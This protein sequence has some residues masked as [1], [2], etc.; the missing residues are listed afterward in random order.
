MLLQSK[1]HTNIKKKKSSDEPESCS[2]ALL[3]GYLVLS[4]K[5]KLEK[6]VEMIVEKRPI[7][8][9]N[10]GFTLQLQF[11]SSDFFKTVNSTIDV[12]F[13]YWMKH[14]KQQAAQS[15]GKIELK[16]QEEEENHNATKEKL[17]HTQIEIEFCRTKIADLVFHT[18]QYIAAS[19]EE[20][21]TLKK[22]LQLQ[23]IEIEQSV[24]KDQVNL[25]GIFIFFADCSNF[26]QKKKPGH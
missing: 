18:Q 13:E 26:N 23:L 4:E 3:L 8:Q 19:L 10:E 16:L 6:A 21:D 9:P 12:Q 17:R 14:N 1:I 15:P 22:Q 11:L 2:S 25:P 20:R 5:L 24:E 7:V